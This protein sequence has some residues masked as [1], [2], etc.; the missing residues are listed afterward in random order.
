MKKVLVTGSGGFIGSALVKRLSGLGFTVIGFDIS[1][2]DIAEE[3][4]LGYLEKED[5]SYVFH[6]AGKTFV[7]ESWSDPFSFYRTNVL[8][9]ANILELCRKTG[10]GLT[11]VSSYLYGKPEYLPIDENHPLKAYN[12][13]SHS[14][15]LAEE[16]CTYYDEQFNLGISIL[17]PFNVYGPGQSEQF[18]IPELIR[19]ML[20]PTISHIEVMDLRPKRDFIFIDDLVEALYLSM[21]GPRG[22]YNVGSG[23]SVSVEEVLQEIKSVTGKDKSIQDMG[24][25]RPNEIFDLFS[26]ISRISK[27]IH[28]KPQINLHEGISRCLRAFEI[29]N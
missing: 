25:E 10:A 15:L 24:M 6:L 23:K 11:Y 27:D 8:G 29:Q 20:D 2:G 12:P 19:K 17:R 26:D 1:N 22:I 14:K 18:L 4:S 21:D 3:K 5:V 13:Y 28:W 9:T 16:I 7:P